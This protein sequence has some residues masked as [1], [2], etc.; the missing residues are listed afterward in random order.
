[1]ALKFGK[2]TLTPAMQAG[3]VSKRL[4]FQEIFTT[5][6]TLSLCVVILL[7]GEFERDEDSACQMAA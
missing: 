1:M 7:V 2:D 5:V 6:A 3:L 4:T